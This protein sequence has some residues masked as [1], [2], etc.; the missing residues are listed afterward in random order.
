VARPKHRKMDMRFRTSN[1]RNLYT[2]GSLKTVARELGKCKLDLVGVQEIRWDKGGGN[3]GAEDY[4][5]FL[6]KSE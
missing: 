5:F 6:S 4:T 2:T 3:E 1:V